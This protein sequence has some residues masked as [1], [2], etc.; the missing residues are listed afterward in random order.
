M[1]TVGQLFS[2]ILVFLIRPNWRLMLG[3]S[4]VPSTLQFFGMLFL[5]ESPR[6]L[7][8]QGEE[9]RSRGIM[10]RVYKSE[11]LENAVLSL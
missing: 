6:W 2:V 3:L 1:I 7:S 4:A 9:D 10:A 5:P 11:F 8:K